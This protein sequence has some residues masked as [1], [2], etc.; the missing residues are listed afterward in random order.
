[1]RLGDNPMR[2]GWNSDHACDRCSMNTILSND[3]ILPCCDHLCVCFRSQRAMHPDIRWNSYGTL[4]VLSVP[5]PPPPTLVNRRSKSRPSVVISSHCLHFFI[6]ASISTYSAI[7]A[8]AVTSELHLVFTRYLTSRL[9]RN[10]RR[11]AGHRHQGTVTT[12]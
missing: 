1:M 7:F 11:D 9:N 3:W 5:D 6:L 2:S 4:A 12:T 8:R 10:L